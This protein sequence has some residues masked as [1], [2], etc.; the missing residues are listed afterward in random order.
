MAQHPTKD[1]GFQRPAITAITAITA[2]AAVAT[3]RG[4]GNVGGCAGSSS[5][6]EHRS[7]LVAGCA[8]CRRVDQRYL[9]ADRHCCCCW[10]PFQHGGIAH[11]R[12]RLWRRGPCV[13]H[14]CQP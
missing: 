9:T 12:S 3:N 2:I 8:G 13:R 4:G 10:R 7:S 5:V 14:P 1:C 11:P 6:R